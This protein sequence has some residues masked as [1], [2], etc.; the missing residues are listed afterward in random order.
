M[1]AYGATPF[2]SRGDGLVAARRVER[3]VIANQWGGTVL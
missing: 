2:F 1:R 3:N